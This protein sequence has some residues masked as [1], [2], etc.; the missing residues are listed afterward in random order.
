MPVLRIPFLAIP[1]GEI[2]SI[3]G[4]NGAGKSTLLQTLC[5]LLP[6]RGEIL[7]RGRE[8]GTELPVLRY[9]RRLAMVLQE[10]LLF[11]TTVYD[12][13][14]SGL[15]IRG[16]KRSDVGPTVMGALERFGI[17][18]LKERSARTLSGGEARKVSL[19]R[20]MATNPEV[21]FLDEPFSA[22]DPIIRE[23]L[24]ED[25][26]RV[27]RQTRTTTVFVTHDR[28]E[29][30]RLST[31]I[32]VMKSGEIIQVGSP[33]DIMDRPADEFVASLAGVETILKGE[34]VRRERS[35]FI[36]SVG[37]REIEA[38]GDR[39]RGER[40]LLCIR[41]EHVGLSLAGENGGPVEVNTY[42]ARVEKIVPMWLY[43]KVRLDC[44]FP[45][46]AYVP[47]HHDDGLH[48]EEGMV[49]NASIKKIHVIG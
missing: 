38:A 12:N 37:G 10:P 45:L 20:A 28:Q 34:V 18:D 19:A 48:L 39:N 44:G 26:E 13:V 7:F 4:P 23:E 22:L 3:I 24:I 49:V 9:R 16:M 5:S 1:E 14:A 43:R 27:L 8:I 41:A 30:L 46:V 11:S 33:E 25:L 15:R 17:A 40:V 42:P 47:D 32:G 21:L 35:S 36:V 6:F 29:A 2:L 31:R